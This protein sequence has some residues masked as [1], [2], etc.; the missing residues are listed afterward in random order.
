[1]AAGAFRRG[2]LNQHGKGP[3]RD[4]DGS[5]DDGHDSVERIDSDTDNDDD[6]DGGDK[7]KT[8][9]ASSDQG[10]HHPGHRRAARPVASGP[11]P[12]RAAGTFG[13]PPAASPQESH[14]D[15]ARP[16]PAASVQERF[17]HDA[18]YRG[19][20]GAAPGYGS[21]PYLAPSNSHQRVNDRDDLHVRHASEHDDSLGD[22]SDDY[23][24]N[25]ERARQTYF[26][27]PQERAAQVMRLGPRAYSPDGTPMPVRS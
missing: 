26:A 5:D 24:A 8:R 7:E 19:G 22:M 27:S 6:D 25:A 2:D 12:T 18:L 9:R 23:W 4:S 3:N 10:H 16:I 15:F 17:Q 11:R 21:A 14:L 13:R 20:G 1:V